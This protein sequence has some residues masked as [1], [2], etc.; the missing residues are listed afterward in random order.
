[1]KQLSPED[2]GASTE[3]APIE[4]GTLSGDIRDVLLTHMRSMRVPWAMLSEDEQ[5][6]KIE[7]ATKCGED[8]VRRAVQAV[9]IGGFPAVVVSVGSVKFDKGVEI[10]L[11]AAGIVEN[12]VRLAEHGKQSA[13]LVLAESA[14][15]FGDR[16]PARPDKQQPGLPLEDAG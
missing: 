11:T 5:R 9:A 7:A 15:Y 8:V 4:L 1:L 2:F 12:I 13:V 14:N 10:K 16:A 3:Q 6:D